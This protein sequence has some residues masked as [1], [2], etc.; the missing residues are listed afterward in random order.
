LHDV[1]VRAEA[2]FDRVEQAPHVD[3]VYKASPQGRDVAN[4]SVTATDGL[5][6]MSRRSRPVS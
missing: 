4:R 5:S 6:A 2:A 3:A 1:F